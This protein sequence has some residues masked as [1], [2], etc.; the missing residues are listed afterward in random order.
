ME[1]SCAQGTSAMGKLAAS[2]GFTHPADISDMACHRKAGSDGTLLASRDEIG[3]IMLANVPVSRRDLVFF[4]IFGCRLAKCS[5]NYAHVRRQEPAIPGKRTS[6]N[7]TRLMM[8]KADGAE[9]AL[10]TAVIH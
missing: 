2:G 8:V 1:P 3:G 7:V 6:W 10:M 9:C 5:E 4:S